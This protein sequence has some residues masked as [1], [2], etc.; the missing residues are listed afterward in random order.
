MIFLIMLFYVFFFIRSFFLS[1]SM[2]KSIVGENPI[3]FLSVFFAG[4]SSLLFLIYL[5]FPVIG[6]YLYI[7]YFTPLL[8]LIGTI[9][10]ILGLLTSIT[11]SLAMKDSWRIGINHQEETELITTGIFQISRNPYFLSFNMVLLGMILC[12]I[13]PVLILTVSVTMILFHQLILNEEKY[14]ESVHG[15]EYLNYKKKV[16]RYL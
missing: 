12:F 5:I 9:L 3:V 1:K 15:L 6:D 2:G 13:S 16:R 11:A 4:I 10:I 14:L 8:F 7:I